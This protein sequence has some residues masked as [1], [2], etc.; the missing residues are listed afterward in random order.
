MPSYTIESVKT[1]RFVSPQ[2]QGVGTP[3]I[4]ED[5]P[6]GVGYRHYLSAGALS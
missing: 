3:V 4:T 2:S 6:V 5:N 1:G